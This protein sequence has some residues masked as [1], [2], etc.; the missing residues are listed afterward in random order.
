MWRFAVLGLVACGGAPLHESARFDTDL[1]A[2]ISAATDVAK[3]NAKQV[4]VD[5]EHEA[6]HTAWQIVAV[7]RER[8][9]PYDFRGIANI[10][11]GS[12]TRYFAR[13]DIRIVGPR[14][15]QVIVAAHASRWAAGDAK[16]TELSD[17][18]PPAWLVE[19]R[20]R[21]VDDINGR[22]HASAIAP[23]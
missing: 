18:N 5:R 21:M 14:P 11:G 2:V 6:V 3:Q 17:D 13:Y 20:D 8:N 10:D 16:P 7:T 15:W 23:R 22:L 1:D 19:R 4:E 9:G 12:A